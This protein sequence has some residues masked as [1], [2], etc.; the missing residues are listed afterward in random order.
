MNRETAELLTTLVGILWMGIVLGAT[1]Y[2]V[3]GLGFSGWWFALAIFIL[4]CT[5]IK[6]GIKLD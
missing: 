2:I 1:S 5:N 3:F 6:H 4:A